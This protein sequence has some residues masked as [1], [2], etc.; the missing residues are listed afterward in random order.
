[1]SM[2]MN[3]A[4]GVETTL[5]KM[6]LAMV[7]PAVL[8]LT[9]PGEIDEIAAYGPADLSGL[10]FLGSV[11]DYIAKVGCFAALGNL[12]ETDEADCVCPFGL[13]VAIS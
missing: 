10:G 2:H 11:G 5:L 9:S 13:F 7:R 12:V 3:W 6:S 4:L 8:V 1:M